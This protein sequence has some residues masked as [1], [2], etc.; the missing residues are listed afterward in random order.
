MY[1]PWCVLNSMFVSQHLNC[2]CRFKL[3]AQNF[4][5]IFGCFSWITWFPTEEA[6]LWM[7]LIFRSDM[8]VLLRNRVKQ[9]ALLIKFYIRIRFLFDQ[10]MVDIWADSILIWYQ[11]IQHFLTAGNIQEL[12]NWN[13][14]VYKC[15]YPTASCLKLAILKCTWS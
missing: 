9:I 13:K 5:F 14:C 6:K 12:M 2:G 1:C 8:P 7:Y 11:V 4:L 10:S 3:V 15:S